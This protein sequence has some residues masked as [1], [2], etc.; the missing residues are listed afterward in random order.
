MKTNYLK[1]TPALLVVLFAS[2]NA[3][4]LSYGGTAPDDHLQYAETSAN[5]GILISDN[6]AS[7][8]SIININN[9][10]NRGNTELFTSS[11]SLTNAAYSAYTGT[12]T[13]EVGFNNGDSLSLSSL[14][15]ADWGTAGDPTS[16]IDIWSTAILAVF[17]PATPLALFETAFINAGGEQR[18]SDP[19]ISSVNVSGGIAYIGLA[20]FLDA[21]AAKDLFPEG[22][23]IPT[24]AQISEIVKVTANSDPNNF[25]YLYAIGKSTDVP[26]PASASNVHIVD[27]SLLMQILFAR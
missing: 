15:A 20:G 1:Y 24:G 10:G 9:N 6:A 5:S 3:S 18:L 16:L 23:S 2:S 13:L 8:S 7:L 25:Q 26:P 19:N 27:G 14:T 22:I 17:S 11:N 4:A 12:T 21:S